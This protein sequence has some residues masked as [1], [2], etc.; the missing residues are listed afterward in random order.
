VLFVLRLNTT[1]LFQIILRI[2]KPNLVCD[3]GS[4]DGTYAL[5]FRKLLPKACIIAFEANPVNANA[6]MQNETLQQKAIWVEHKVVYFQP[7][8][9]TFYIEK[10]DPD[11]QET[12]R[13]GISSMRLR[14]DDS[15]GSTPVYV[16]AVRLDDYLLVLQPSFTTAVLWVDVEGCAFEVLQSIEKINNLVL[17]V[18]VEVEEKEIWQGQR[19]R[20]DVETLMRD[21]GFTAIAQGFNAVQTDLVFVRDKRRG[22]DYFKLKAIIATAWLLSRFQKVLGV[23]F[24]HLVGFYLRRLEG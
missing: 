21:Y 6:M 16:Q 10:P 3:I 17:A 8:M 9:S 4:M 19:L 12:W 1:L 24:H 22:F 7:G 20:S 15:L 13:C 14:K 11:H 23:R 2:Y 18:H 5:R